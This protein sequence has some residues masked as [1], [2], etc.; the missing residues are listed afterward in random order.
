MEAPTPTEPPS[1]LEM[2]PARTASL[3]LSY[4]LTTTSPAVMAEPVVTW[5]VVVL[6]ETSTANAPATVAVE[7]APEAA[8][9]M[10]WAPR[11][12]ANLPS[13]F[14]VKVELTVTPP[15]LLTGVSQ[16]LEPAGIS[17]VRATPEMVA[18]A[19]LP[20]TP[21]ETAAPMALAGPCVMAAPVA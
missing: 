5:A 7:P 10:L 1:D 4:A 16:S 21:T 19:S 11:S 3:D 14:W 2:A 18:M 9:A 20:L 15:A 12:P 17:T 8:P 6:L 13:M